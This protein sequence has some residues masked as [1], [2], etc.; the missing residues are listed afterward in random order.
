MS[1]GSVCGAGSVGT[2]YRVYRRSTTDTYDYGSRWV[3]DEDY[4]HTP[5]SVWRSEPFPRIP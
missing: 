3:S 4:L 1:C 2:V 5:T